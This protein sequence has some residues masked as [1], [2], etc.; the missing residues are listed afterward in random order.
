M[1]VRKLYYL[2][3]VGAVYA[4]SQVIPGIEFEAGVSKGQLHILG[5]FINFRDQELKEKVKRLKEGNENKITWM[6]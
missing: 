3:L 2:L 5:L 6:K 4:I 1:A